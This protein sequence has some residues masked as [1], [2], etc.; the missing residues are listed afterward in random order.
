MFTVP[1]GGAG[2]Y[3][4]YVNFWSTEGENAIFDVR[5]NEVLRC[6]AESDE[7]VTTPDDNG[8]PSCGFVTTL[9]EGKSLFDSLTSSSILGIVVQFL[10]F[11][12]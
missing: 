8:T 9:S 5:V 6:R 12:T 4:F 3:Y 2:L 7:A 1:S 11:Q 10:Y